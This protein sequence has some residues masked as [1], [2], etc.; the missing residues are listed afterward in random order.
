M[1]CSTWFHTCAH[2]RTQSLGLHWIKFLTQ[3]AC[4]NW[5][6]VNLG[7]HISSLQGEGCRTRQYEST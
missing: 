3:A 5:T 4:H 1:F 7:K 6:S 2:S